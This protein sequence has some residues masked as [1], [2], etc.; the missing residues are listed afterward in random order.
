LRFGPADLRHL[1][2]VGTLNARIYFREYL[3]RNAAYPRRTNFDVVY[4]PCSSCGCRVDAA[5]LCFGPADL[6]NLGRADTPARPRPFPQISRPERGLPAPDKSRR[7]IWS[8]LSPR[9]PRP[10]RSVAFWPR[11]LEES[12]PGRHPHAQTY[13]REHLARDAAYP[14]QTKLDVVYGP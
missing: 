3:A 14:R 13:F 1:G 4:G 9:M 12:R 2:R 8:L 10:R 7:S 6:R 11:R 5:W